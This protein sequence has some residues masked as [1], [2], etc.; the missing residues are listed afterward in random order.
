MAKQELLAS[1]QDR[2]RESSRKDKS[3]IL[4]EFIAVTGHH[5]KHGIRLLAQSAEGGVGTGLV[6]GWRIYN[7]AVWEVV[8]LI[9]EA[10]EGGDA[11]PGGVHGAP[12]SSGSGSRGENT[13]AVGQRGHPGPVAETGA[14]HGGGSAQT[15]AAV[16]SRSQHS[17]AHLRRLE[18]ATARVPGD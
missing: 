17:G 9:W 14:G 2:Y 11:S 5:R 7:D 8:I 16:I 1:I 10:P 3:K 18:P 12:R 6:K 13:S 15:P 4:D